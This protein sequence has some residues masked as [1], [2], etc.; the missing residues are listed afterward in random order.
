MV[1][2][3]TAPEYSKMLNAATTPCY[4]RRN[5]EISDYGV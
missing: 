2:V 4:Q 3:L 1:E 5:E